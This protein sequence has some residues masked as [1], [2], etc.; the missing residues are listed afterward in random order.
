M[1]ELLNV[2]KL[3]ILLMHYPVD[4]EYIETSILVIFAVV[5]GNNTL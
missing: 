3:N 5:F 1:L 4:D 2:L